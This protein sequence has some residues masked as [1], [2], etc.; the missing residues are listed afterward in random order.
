LPPPTVGPREDQSL[1]PAG[2]LNSTFSAITGKVV[3]SAG[4]KADQADVPAKK[5][6]QYTGGQGCDHARCADLLKFL[7][8]RF[9]PAGAQKAAL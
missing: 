8:L 1:S 5:R 9:K 7:S 4:P 6:V 3:N 2:S